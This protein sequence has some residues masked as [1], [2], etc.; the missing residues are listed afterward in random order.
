MEVENRAA[1][2]R[3]VDG[4][5]GPGELVTLIL[6]TVFPELVLLLSRVIFG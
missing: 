4:G 3:A 2:I 6:I 5:S 1:E